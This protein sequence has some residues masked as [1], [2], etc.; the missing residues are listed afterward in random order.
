[1]PEEISDSAELTQSDRQVNNIKLS[2]IVTY[3]HIESLPTQGKIYEWLLS[4][5]DNTKEGKLTNVDS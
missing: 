4:V 1:M 3:L 5:Y 2:M